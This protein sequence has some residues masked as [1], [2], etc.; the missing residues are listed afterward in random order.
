MAKIY[1]AGSIFGGREQQPLYR[2]IIDYLKQKGHLVLS[3][4][5]AS[6]K[7]F[8]EEAHLSPSEIFTQDINWLDECNFVIAEVTVPSLGVGY[9]ICYSLSKFKPTLCICHKRTK[10]SAMIAG[11]INPLLNVQY[12]GDEKEAIEKIESFLVRV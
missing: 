9:E 12:Y 6:D 2:V 1:F 3:E 10:L 5:V 7:V 11:N 8:D 4:H